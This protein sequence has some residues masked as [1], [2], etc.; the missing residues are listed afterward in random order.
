[1]LG[2]T[3]M[4]VKDVNELIVIDNSNNTLLEHYMY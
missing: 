1:M 3:G 2:T 4:D